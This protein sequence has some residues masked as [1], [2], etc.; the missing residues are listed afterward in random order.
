MTERYPLR[1]AVPR[2][3]GAGRSWPADSHWPQWWL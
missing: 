1:R 3:G 2:P